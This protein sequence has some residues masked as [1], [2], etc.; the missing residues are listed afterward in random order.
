MHIGRITARF[1]V[2]LI[3][4]YAPLEASAA[5]ITVAGFTFAAGSQFHS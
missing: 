3:S 2:A 4:L 1:A 5:P